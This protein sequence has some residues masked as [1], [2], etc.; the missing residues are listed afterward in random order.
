MDQSKESAPLDPKVGM[1]TK[2][3]IRLSLPHNNSTLGAW[4][5]SHSA[6]EH[7]DQLLSSPTEES[8]QTPLGL[9]AWRVRDVCNAVHEAV[10]TDS[11]GISALPLQVWDPLVCASGL[12]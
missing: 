3:P 4:P 8:E 11:P 5:S 9:E 10:E 12:P 1:K 6:D 2:C 7:G